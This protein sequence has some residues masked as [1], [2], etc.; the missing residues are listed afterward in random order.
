[1]KITVVGTGYVGL[2]NAVL[3]SQRSKV[4]ALDIIKEK[5]DLINNRVSPIKDGE[6]E[7]FFKNKKLDLT[8]TLDK[9][10]AYKDAK[11]VIIATPTDYDT[12][13][14]FFDT[15]SVDSTIKDVEKYNKNAIIIIKSTVPVGYNEDKLQDLPNF[16][17]M[18]L[19]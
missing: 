1:M 2:S 11:F 13:Q 15:S 4:Y 16:K 10:E 18:Y 6:I 5:V 8:A 19:Q 3:L 14:N 12:K 7:D 9:E 17:I